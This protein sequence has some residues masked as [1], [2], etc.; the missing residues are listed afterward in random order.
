MAKKLNGNFGWLVALLLAAGGWAY[1]LG[2]QAQ[3]INANQK[4]LEKQNEKKADKTVVEQGFR[5]LE[6]K[7]DMIIDQL[8]QKQN[9]E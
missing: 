7:L 9:K 1:S 8:K 2:Y 6:S 3:T 5:G 4:Q